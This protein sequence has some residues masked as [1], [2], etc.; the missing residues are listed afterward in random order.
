MGEG[1]RGVRR[2][3]D[4][5]VASGAASSAVALV[6]DAER[7]AWEAAAGQAREGVPATPETRFD[8]AS[9]TKPFVSTL[10]LVLDDEGVLPLAA[11]IA[12]LWPQADPRLGR[13]PL[14]DL[15]RH[16][17]G[18]RAWAP[19]YHLCRSR[20]EVLALILGGTLLGA[21]SGTYSDLGFILLGM[22]IEQVTG[23]E[24]QTAVRSRVLAPLGLTSV[25]P[26]PGVLPDI[27]ESRMD[28]GKEVQLA[29]KLGLAIA[30]LPLSAL[31][32]PQDG[33][34]RFLIR[35]SGGPSG[36]RGH[37]AG[38]AGL[39]GRARDL[40]AL[41]A[42]WLAPGRLLKPAAVAAA[43]AG[44]GGFALGWWRRT[45]R[46]SAGRALSR[47]AFGHTGFAGG[48]LWIDPEAGRILVLLSAR[49]DAME[50]F[51][52]RRRRFHTLAAHRIS[53]E[54]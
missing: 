23:E 4:D 35:L 50:N 31:G 42:E 26:S 18:L 15:L 49:T 10:A 45:V 1:G 22:T 44:G 6:G 37:M 5:L 43:L 12:E 32:F 34:A 27:A 29:A 14:S 17:S 13:R 28:T 51:N 16:R 52:R 33:N 19:L 40:W 53:L 36:G 3:L 25:E 20:E 46:G 2:F 39:F 47:A 54:G 24:L 41:G 9:L 11:P 30:P 7:I 38:H 48:S 8:F 21:R